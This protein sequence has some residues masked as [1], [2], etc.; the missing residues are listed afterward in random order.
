VR[1]KQ[2]S[3]FSPAAG[4]KSGQSNRKRNLMKFHTRVPAF[5]P[6]A[7]ARHAGFRVQGSVQPLAAEVASLIKKE[8]LVVKF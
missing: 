6:R 7:S 3:G 2:G 4:L 8:T 5:A 1:G